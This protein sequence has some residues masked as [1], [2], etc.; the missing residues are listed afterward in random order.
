[1][2]R[3]LPP[4]DASLKMNRLQDPTSEA[5]ISTEHLVAVV[6]IAAVTAQPG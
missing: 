2:I 1:V 6:D 3:I 4:H 5:L